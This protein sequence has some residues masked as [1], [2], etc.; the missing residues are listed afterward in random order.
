MLEIRGEALE[1]GAV[2]ARRYRLERVVGEGGMGVVWAARELASGRAVALKLLREGAAAEPKNQER[3][4]REARAAMGV[5]HANVAKVE[6]VLE[7]D[8]GV[9]FLVMELL[10]GESLRDLL[11]RRRSL[12]LFECA[13]ILLPVVDAVIAAHE[14]RVVHR[15]LKPENV[16]LEHG[17]HVRVLDFGIA[18]LLPKADET[19]SAS[20][21]STGAL[22]G[23]PIYMAPE[24]VFGDDDVDGRADIWSLG[25]M[26]YEC[27]AGKRP[28]D[29][30]GFGP[31]IKRITTET[32]VPLEDARPGL[33]RRLTS[34]VGRMLSRKREE[35]PALSEVRAV[36]AGLVEAGEDGPAPSEQ[37]PAVTL[38]I[39]NVTP[40]AA[41]T[42]LVPGHV[43]SAP[44]AANAPTPAAPGPAHGAPASRR[45][46]PLVWAAAAV[47]TFA[48][49]ALGGMTLL[50]GFK[51][52]RKS[53]VAVTPVASPFGD[54]G[55]AP[56]LETAR[57]I[58]EAT[59]AQNRRDGATCLARLDAYDADV[60][61]A[62]NGRVSTD[63]ASGY[64]GI[65]GTCLMLVGRCREGKALYRT[66]LTPFVQPG[67]GMDVDES[68]EQVVVE[69]CEG[70][71][72]TPREELLRVSRNFAQVSMNKRTPTR[73]ECADWRA[74]QE[75]L[76][77]QVP[78]RG[79]TDRV[80][81]LATRT[82]EDAVDCF[83]RAGDCE[84]AL[85]I[86]RAKWLERGSGA[87]LDAAEREAA[88]RTSYDGAVAATP[89]RGR[90]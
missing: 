58:R 61:I 77:K 28:T 36:L 9:P 67:S 33:P 26:V 13:R 19:A 68:V 83:A 3:F 84:T 49:A 53:G 25:I 24:Q 32:L 10:E 55:A 51:R 57:L 11:Q 65:R 21:T 50:E 63:P 39:P 86:H 76:L 56:W 69:S 2:L 48:A 78:A 17:A 70:N 29:G 90:P 22:I 27:L 44:P 14:T 15:D 74:A 73:A 71:E 6:A 37:E 30:D 16:F 60:V 54:A 35:R 66:W 75:R 64:A 52:P 46:R 79:P 42:M 82:E 59:E 72:V 40:P 43:S 87:G 7:T 20:L 12:S 18:K 88:S 47:V 81:L 45:A 89:C 38:R 23:T 31:I 62:K 1:S 8:A 4:L 41:A 34:L 80:A 5:V 85:R